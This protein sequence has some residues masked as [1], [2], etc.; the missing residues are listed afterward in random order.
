MIL[1]LFAKVSGKFLLK[2]YSCGKIYAILKD[3]SFPPFTLTFNYTNL[4]YEECF[5]VHWSQMAGKNG[6]FLCPEDG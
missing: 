6:F 4:R 5:R 3:I 2:N 1:G